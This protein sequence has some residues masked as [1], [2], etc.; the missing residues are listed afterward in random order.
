MP[1]KAA[2]A[3][4]L[5][6]IKPIVEVP[7]S[8]FWLFTAAVIGAVIITGVLVWWRVRLQKARVDASR[9]EALRGLDALDLDGETKKAVY[10]FSLLGH[11]VTTPKTESTFRELLAAL[12]PYKFKKEVPALDPALKKRMKQF[13]KEA[14]RG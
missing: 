9:A 2:A 10:D 3:L 14:H 6:D 7:D 13:I 11:F 12:E 1:A 4:P 5:K 8:S